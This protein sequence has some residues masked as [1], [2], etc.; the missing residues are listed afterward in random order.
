[1]AGS[2]LLLATTNQLSER[3]AAAPFLWV[4]PLSLYLIT[5]ILT[6]ESDRWYRRPLFATPREPS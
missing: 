6:F 1:M 4:A 5:F 2:T 3:I